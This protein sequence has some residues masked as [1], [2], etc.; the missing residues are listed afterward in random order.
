MPKKKTIT[1]SQDEAFQVYKIL[2]K[3]QQFLHQPEHHRNEWAVQ[4]WLQDDSNKNYKDID[5]ALRDIVW[6]WLPKK[7]QKQIE[8][9]LTDDP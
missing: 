7:L 6:N 8:E 3:V 2:E 1:I 4:K 5:I 9:G